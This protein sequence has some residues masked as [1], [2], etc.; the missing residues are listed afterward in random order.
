MERKATVSQNSLRGLSTLEIS[1][2]D[3]VEAMKEI[4][5]YVDITPGMLNRFIDGP[6]IMPCSDCLGPPRE[7][8]S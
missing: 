2:A 8:T 6:T 3:I 1:D 4:G 7:R 5:G